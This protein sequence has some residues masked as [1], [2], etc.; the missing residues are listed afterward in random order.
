MAA[1][2]VR[3]AKPA[4]K[5]PVPNSAMLLMFCQLMPTRFSASRLTSA[6]LT[7][8]CT[9]VGASIRMLLITLAGLPLTCCTAS[10]RASSATTAERTVPVSTIVSPWLSKVTPLLG[11]IWSSAPLMRLSG[12]VTRTMVLSSTRSCASTA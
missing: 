11:W 3:T 4:R 8:I 9:C 6:T 5:L 10:R 12:E 1:A 2:V 7:R